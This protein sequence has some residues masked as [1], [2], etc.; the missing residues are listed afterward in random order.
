[1]EKLWECR[2]TNG[3]WGAVLL[4]KDVVQGH[5]SG[6]GNYGRDG[7]Y[8]GRATPLGE[9]AGTKT[10][11]LDPEPGSFVVCGGD[12]TPVEGSGA[13]VVYRE[14]LQSSSYGSII[15]ARPGAIL[16]ST[17]YKG[18][19]AW[20][21]ALCE[22]GSLADVPA[23]VVLALGLVEPDEAPEPVQAAEPPSTAMA[24]ALRAVGVLQ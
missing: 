11:R 2:S 16:R 15:S 19:S 8:P 22:D 10:F 9:V 21:R 13:I 12:V 14:S 5:Q 4:A 1:M 20:F 23:S 6:S 24:A 18:R 17:G 3:R 7:S